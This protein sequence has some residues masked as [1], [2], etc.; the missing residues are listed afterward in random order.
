MAL[1]KTRENNKEELEKIAQKTVLQKEDKITSELNKEFGKKFLTPNDKKEIDKM[2]PSKTYI[3][4]ESIAFNSIMKDSNAY[5]I[6]PGRI[7]MVCASPDTGKTTV[8]L[9][10]AKSC[11]EKGYQ[12]IFYN[13]EQKLNIKLLDSMGINR[14][15][16]K[17]FILVNT[18]YYDETFISIKRYSQMSPPKFF[19][20]DSISNLISKE[21]SKQMARDAYYMSQ[22]LK[23]VNGVISN[24]N[25]ICI[26]IAQERTQGIGRGVTYNAPTGGKASTYYSSLLLQMSKISE[27]EDDNKNVT[28]RELRVKIKKND[29]SGM[30]ETKFYIRPGK[31]FY[32]EYEL[33]E[34]AKK[35]GIIKSAGSWISYHAMKFQGMSNLLACIEKDKSLFDQIKKEVEDKSIDEV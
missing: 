19:I 16:P 25:S 27:T 15:D 5:G 30:K 6:V 18:N 26:M 32:P 34:T 22:F 3:E 33:V 14:T 9:S 12:L 28:S 7:Y 11:I 10:I 23:Y 24:S 8:S 21:E 31:G 1:K 29:F 17:K 13:A 2:D 4:T 20:I 35:K